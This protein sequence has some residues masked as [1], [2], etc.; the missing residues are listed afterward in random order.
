MWVTKPRR[1][2]LITFVFLPSRYQP[3]LLLV[4]REERSDFIEMSDGECEFNSA[5]LGESLSYK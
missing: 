4:N 2:S 3:R 1:I 5:A